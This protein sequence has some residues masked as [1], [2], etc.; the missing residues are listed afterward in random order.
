M[1][2]EIE[3]AVPG[4]VNAARLAFRIARRQGTHAC[5]PLS[6]GVGDL[7]PVAADP[8][9]GAVDAPSSA[10][11]E[12]AVDHHVEM[13]VPG[14]H[15]IVAEHN[16]RKTRAVRLHAGIPA[17]AID[18]GGTAEDQAATAPLEHSGTDLAFPR[19][20]RDRFPGDARLSEGLGHAIRRPRLL[21][22]RFEDQADLQRDDGQPKRVHARGVRGQ[23]EAEHGS[24]SLKTDRHAALLAVAPR[25]HVEVETARQRRENPPHLGEYEG[26]LLHVRAAETLGDARGS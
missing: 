5:H 13:L 3:S 16:L 8:D 15:L 1:A 2:R 23:H 22:A 14:V 25:Q 26:V 19:I 4:M 6:D 12:D 11:A 10:V 17:I 24:F 9:A 20:D 18:R 21:R 7:A